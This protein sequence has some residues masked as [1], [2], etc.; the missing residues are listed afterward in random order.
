L[1]EAQEKLEAIRLLRRIV[2]FQPRDVAL[3]RELATL[4]LRQGRPVD[5]ARVLRRAAAL[6]PRDVSVQGMLAAAYEASGFPEDALAAYKT[7]R[8]LAPGDPK[9]GEK[10]A[11]MTAARDTA[12]GTP[13]PAVSEPGEASRSEK[14][15]REA[16]RRWNSSPFDG[17]ITPAALESAL[18]LLARVIEEDP[19]HMPAY[20][21]SATILEALGRYED[22]AAAVGRGLALSPGYEPAEDQQRR[23][24]LLAALKRKSYEPSELPAMVNEIGRLYWKAGD[25]ETAIVYLGRVV[26]LAPRDGATWSNLALCYVQAGQLDL[27][28]A[29][30]KKA[31]E[32]GQGSDGLKQQIRELES[33]VGGRR[34]P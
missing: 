7:V 30:S 25:V 26:L 15:F 13:P 5:A 20:V 16:L 3:H 31:I 18:G 32:L 27:A 34:L 14:L 21:A 1:Q 19:K 23:L 22:A 12:A 9:V 33:I 28:L 8:E 2:T 4:Y 11:S 17:S 6:A 10:I 24:E 29:A